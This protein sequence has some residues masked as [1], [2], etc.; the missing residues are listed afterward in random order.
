M[1]MKVAPL[2]TS[3]LLLG[4]G[5]STGVTLMSAPQF[6]PA[7]NAPLAGVL[8]LTTDV[9][10]RVSVAVSDGTDTWTRDFFDYSLEHAVTLAGFKPGRTN[11][12]LVTVYDQAQNAQSSPQP[13]IFVTPLLPPDFP[14]STVLHSEP[15]K[16]EPGYTLFIVLNRSTNAAYVTIVNNAGEVVWYSPTPSLGDLDVHQMAN[17][18]FFIEEQAPANRFREL[19]LLGQTV[20]TW[21]APPAYPVNNHDGLLTDHGT[22]LYLSDVS[23]VVSNFPTSSTN[24]QPQLVT[25][26]VDDNPVVEISYT[27]GALLNAWSP[28]DMLDPTRVTYLTYTYQVP[29]GVDN[30]HANA[31]LEDPSDDSIIVSLRTQNAVFK[32]L[33]STGQLKWILGSHANW[34]AKFQPYLLTPIG[35][36]FAWSYGQHAPEITPQHTLLLYDDGNFRAEPFAPPVAD[37]SNYSR[38]V[39]YRIDETNQQISQVWDTSQAAG[40]RLYTFAVGDADWL[41]QSG[42]VLVTYGLISYVNGLHPSAT[43]SNASMAR[44]REYTHDAV[45]RIVF[46]LEFFDHNNLQPNYMGCLCYRSYR[47]PDL[48]A[49]PSMPVTDLSV[50]MS[51]AGPR[52]QFSGDPM[53]TYTVEA[54]NDRLQWQQ[55]GTP[56]PGPQPD[57]FVLVDS[58]STSAVRFYRVVT[59]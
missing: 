1:K 2:F 19:N 36:N 51:A 47:I 46:E 30:E 18:D 27:D 43:A 14:R 31:V 5:S 3:A 17:G 39:E 11:Q 21:S 48:Y 58:G 40:D 10:S 34:A 28:L 13:L 38:A 6:V 37:Q 33:R 52:L 23:R 54:A 56:T 8:Y 55:I 35:T 9:G 57:T 16:M 53:R 49:H 41:A 15:D 42:N 59:H 12:I 50:T 22:I 20:R 29:Y 25:A 45:P 44:I 24:P 32:F 26:T 4:A 7:T